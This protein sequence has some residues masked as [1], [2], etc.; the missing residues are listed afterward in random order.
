MQ[1]Y[2]TFAKKT[3]EFTP[4]PLIRI[5]VCGITPYDAAHLGHIFTFMTYDLFQRRLEDQGHIVQ[6]VRNITDVDEP[7]FKRAKQLGVP[8]MELAKREI[9]SFH[10]VLSELSFRVP[11]GE[12]R[13]SEYILQMADA[14][15]E[16]LD[17]DYAYRLDGDIY[18]DSSRDQQF[19]ELSAYSPTIQHRLLAMR[20]GDPERVG[21]RQ[22]LDFLLWRSITDPHDT[23][24]W[25]TVI[26][27]GRPGWHIECSVMSSELL[28]LPFDVHG[29][30]DDLIF[31]HHE[32]EAAQGR[33]LGYPKVADRWLHVAP[34][35]LYAEKMSKSL[36]NLV[37]AK[38]L[39][40][41]YE[42]S[43]IRLA[44]MNYHF[45]TGG[46]WCPAF[47]A[48]AKHL[49]EDLKKT[50]PTMNPELLKDL[51]SEIRSAL[52]DNLD[53]P[54]VI[55]ALCGSVTRTPNQIHQPDHN[56]KTY[57]TVISELLGLKF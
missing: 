37:F 41:E 18:F 21:K 49:Y 42:P 54:R 57:L 9:D 25:D 32:S 27:H 33:A 8:Y 51:I 52:D 16:M 6:L 50:L 47:L 13:A 22:P 1:F 10:T 40:Q 45:R 28:G 48:Q 20:G 35:L 44:L 14:V 4:K 31:P 55:W 5:Y 19:G 30:G 17:I 23:A 36:G 15:Q 34:L 38:D 24:A 7:I 11:F 3:M 12:P 46:E 43:V 56:T 2:D 53:T 26:G 39:L 29:G